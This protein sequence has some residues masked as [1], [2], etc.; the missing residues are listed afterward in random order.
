MAT[1]RSEREIKGSAYEAYLIARA[2]GRVPTRLAG[3]GEGVT[4]LERYAIALGVHHYFAGIEPISADLL[5]EKWTSVLGEE[6]QPDASVPEDV[7]RLAEYVREHFPEDVGPTSA[8]DAAI[9]RLDELLG[10]RKLIRDHVEL[11]KQAVEGAHKHERR[12]AV[13]YLRRWPNAVPEVLAEQ[14]EAGAHLGASDPL[15]PSPPDPG[16]KSPELPGPWTEI[17][18]DREEL[19]RDCDYSV[20][21]CAASPRERPANCDVQLNLDFASAVARGLT[22]AGIAWVR[23]RARA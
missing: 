23:K 18:G 3:T 14:I 20:V 12:M 10:A 2:T 21:L 9:L 17:A 22:P 15:G 5:V 6:S 8:V 7:A 11:V 19:M 4:L 1:K 16:E 13:E